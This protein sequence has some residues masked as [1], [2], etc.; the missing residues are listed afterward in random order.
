LDGFI[1]YFPKFTA[2]LFYDYKFFEPIK[3]EEKVHGLEMKKLRLRLRLRLKL[4]LSSCPPK[5]E[6]EPIF[7]ITINGGLILSSFLV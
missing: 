7:F 5:D 3:I 2:S 4:R 1:G 6:D